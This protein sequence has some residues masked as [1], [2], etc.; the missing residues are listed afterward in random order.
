MILPTDTPPAL[1]P[2]GSDDIIDTD[3]I[4]TPQQR[5]ADFNKLFTW[6]NKE[7]T[8][9]IASELYY[10]ELRVHMNAPPL[11][12]YATMAD[13]TAEAPRVLYCSHFNAA[14]L[15]AFRMLP[16]DVQVERYDHWVQQNIAF[17]ELEL[18]AKV[19]EE[20][21]A[22]VMRARTQPMETGDAIDG[23]GNSPARP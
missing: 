13:F 10:R 22:A 3:P 9:S 11:G 17:H 8:F 18:A 20:I 7:I 15:R 6:R 14:Q 1:P 5:E 12:S 21:N 2:P 16:P 19:A 4:I 23:L